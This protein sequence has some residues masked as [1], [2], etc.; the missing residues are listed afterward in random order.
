MAWSI[1]FKTSL[2]SGIM[3]IVKSTL[4][5]F[6]Q[7]SV[8]RATAQTPQ[9]SSQR[10]HRPLRKLM[11]AQL[12]R[13]AVQSIAIQSHLLCVTRASATAAVLLPLAV[14]CQRPLLVAVQK[15]GKAVWQACTAVQHSHPAL[16]TCPVHQDRLQHSFQM[17]MSSLS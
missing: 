9:H 1:T 2:H 7:L 16:E 14:L 3:V 4:R 10:R 12:Q 17:T 6:L 5:S 8:L 13:A 15:R 11:L